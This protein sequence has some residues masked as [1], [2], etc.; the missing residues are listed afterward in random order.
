MYPGHQLR[1][2]ALFDSHLFPQ[3]YCGW[4]FSFLSVFVLTLH[5]NFHLLS[6]SSS[7]CFHSCQWACRENPFTPN[8]LLPPLWLWR[9]SIL[10]SSVSCHLSCETDL[11][12][13]HYSPRRPGCTFNN[14][15]WR[16]GSNRGEVHFSTAAGFGYQMSVLW[17]Q[18]GSNPFWV[19]H[20][21]MP[22]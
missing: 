13:I 15:N 5:T 9:K 14:L 10:L 8:M 7:F 18:Q 16:L 3:S 19:F 17:T 20:K 22:V 6:C 2:V 1:C 21:D 11:T 4:F 12:L